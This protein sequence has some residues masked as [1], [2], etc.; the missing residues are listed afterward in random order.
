MTGYTMVNSLLIQYPDNRIPVIT[1]PEVLTP[2]KIKEVVLRVK[3]ANGILVHTM[4]NSQLRKNLVETCRIHGVK[5][6]DFMG[7][8]ADYLE[9]ELGL[10]SSNFPGLYRRV[11]TE[12]FKR[13]EA[14]EFATH[15]DDGLNPDRLFDAEIIL[16]GVS[17]TGKTPLSIYLSVFGWKVANV[18]IIPDIDPPKQLFEVDP[19]RVFGL[20]I[21]INYLIAQRSKRLAR[22]GNIQNHDYV[23]YSHV[24]NEIQYANLIF[25]RGRFTRISVTNKPIET[26]ANEIIGFITDRFAHEDR[27]FELPESD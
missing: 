10:V 7:P 6:I 19:N 8:L 1:V 12:Y 27:S 4:I 3:K 22:M 15:H 17:R 21:N 14:I 18:P 20:N 26:S 9:Q 25:D 5:E 11:N 2:E 24:R 13:I 23:D 16:T